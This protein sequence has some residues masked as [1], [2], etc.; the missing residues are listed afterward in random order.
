MGSTS[1]NNLPYKKSASERIDRTYL[2]SSLEKPAPH[3]D[4][5]HQVSA[6]TLRYEQLLSIVASCEHCFGRY[7]QKIE[8]S[9]YSNGITSF[10]DHNAYQDKNTHAVIAATVVAACKGGDD[11]DGKVDQIVGLRKILEKRKAEYLA[12]QDSIER[13]KQEW[14]QSDV[15][16]NTR[17]LL[18]D[19]YGYTD[20]QINRDYITREIRDECAKLGVTRE[21]IGIIAADRAQLYFKG[22]WSNVGL[23]EIETQVD[24]GTDMVII[25]KEGVIVQISLFSNKKRIALL[26]TRGFL[27]EYA[28]RL[29]RLAS[30][31]GCNISII[32][33]WD[34]SGLL[35]FLKMRKIIPA[36]KRIG[37]DFK[38][39]EELGLKEEDVAEDYT[40]NE[41]HLNPLKR[42]LDALIED[43]R[44]NR[45]WDKEKEYMYLKSYLEYLKTKR[46]EINSI[47]AQ[48]KDNKKF[49]DWIENK[50]RDAFPDRDFTRMDVI[51]EYV[52][53][54]EL[55]G[56]NDI[57][58][59][60]GTAALKP[61]REE[62]Q[63]KLANN[64]IK[65]EFLFDRTNRIKPNYDTDDYEAAI[66]EQSKKIIQNDNELK[67]FVEKIGEVYEH[68]KQHKKQKDQEQERG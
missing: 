36:L 56:V 50:L 11:K 10:S 48:L 64:S 47:I 18:I 62:L 30:E 51:P 54:D 27:V 53:P 2:N 55:Q 26:N 23:D 22:K 39:L 16:Y 28:S 13:K 59:E 67:P 8:E 4:A 15:F 45:E 37:V 19:E 7:I 3:T 65:N 33:D 57:M 41:D 40:P 31:R 52:K 66:A 21:Q 49:W 14:T 35:I 9:S 38:T 58:E 43:A 6:V 34:V 12:I 24:Y 44:K 1:I 29:A 5:K 46:I 32:V 68:L 25:E 42:E 17:K 20:K 60:I 61:R 63:D